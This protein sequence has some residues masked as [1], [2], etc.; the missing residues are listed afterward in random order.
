MD[1][2]KQITKTSLIGIGTNIVLSIFKIIVGSLSNSIAILLD[3]VNN[4]SDACSSII[5][6]V[7]IKLAKRKPNKEHPYGYGRIEYFSAIVISGI[8]L[9]AGITSMIESAKKIFHPETPQ[10]SM[11]TIF[12]VVVAILVKI[13]LGRY[14]SKQGKKYNSTALVASG[15]DASFDAIL[16]VSTL[17]SAL[18]LY[19]LKWNIDG[20]VGYILSF[21]IVK[22]GTEMLMESTGSIMGNRP[23]SEITKDIKKTVLSIPDVVGVYDLILHNYGPDVAIGSL[24]VEVPATLSARDI[25]VLSRTIQRTILE[26]FQV[27]LTVG[28]YALDEEHALERNQIRNT[29]LDNKGVLGCHAIY[30]NDENKD[31]SFDV[32][33]DFTVNDKEKLKDELIKKISNTFNGYNIDVNFDTNYSD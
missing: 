8:V 18:I 10:Y 21:F 1:R 9:T 15:A 22:A 19:L 3:A 5:T 11:L 2:E 31:I 14:V 6:I 26:K 29:V 27:I 23:D 32:L 24:H 13:G 20:I 7:G 4:L 12:V 28:I 30:I 33:V 16:S 25:H 17:I